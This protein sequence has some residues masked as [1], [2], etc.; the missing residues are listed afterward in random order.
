LS[1]F[2]WAS[3]IGSTSTAS[4]PRSLRAI[5]ARPLRPPAAADGD[6]P[7]VA[8]GDEERWRP[9]K[10]AHG[11]QSAESAI[12]HLRRR[13]CSQDRSQRARHPRRGP[14]EGGVCCV[15]AS[16]VAIHR[17]QGRGLPTLP[18]LPTHAPSVCVSTQGGM[19]GNCTRPTLPTTAQNRLLGERS[20]ATTGHLGGVHIAG[21]TGIA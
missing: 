4:E 19:G 7:G 12:C 14:V 15:G 1:L 16:A 13:Y 20:K 9:W 3:R 11:R 5:D 10:P 2:V 17:G 6:L 18:T 8:S 21:C